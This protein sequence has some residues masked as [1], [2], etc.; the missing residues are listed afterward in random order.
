MTEHSKTPWRIAGKATIRNDDGWIATLEQ[1]NRAK[2]AAYIVR[3][4]NC[5]AELVEALS[6]AMHAL[7]SYEY[8]NA[9]TE[10]AKDQA[11]YCESVLAK[12]RGEA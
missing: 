3:A 11:D 5:H 7:R 9:S 1:W 12:A 6:G 10:L 2:N 4:V 8:G